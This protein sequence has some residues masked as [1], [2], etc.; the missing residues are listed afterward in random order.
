MCIYKYMNMYIHV[1]IN[2]IQRH[3]LGPDV[4]PWALKGRGN[5]LSCWGWAHFTRQDVRMVSRSDG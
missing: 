3:W 4:P 2:K 1:H 5:F